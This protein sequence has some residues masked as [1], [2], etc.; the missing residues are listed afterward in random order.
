MNLT[1][2]VMNMIGIRRRSILWTNREVKAGSNA[3]VELSSQRPTASVYGS[4]REVELDLIPGLIRG[5]RSPL[6]MLA[7]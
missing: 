5:V 6:H 1:Q 2:N 3:I 4:D 7:R